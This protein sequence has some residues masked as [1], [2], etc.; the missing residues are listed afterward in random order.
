MRT[1]AALLLVVVVVVVVMVEFVP[2]ADALSAIECVSMVLVLVCRIPG[3]RAVPGV[4]VGVGL[5]VV[6]SSAPASGGS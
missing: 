4:A 2:N 6:G 5:A 1:L 3:G